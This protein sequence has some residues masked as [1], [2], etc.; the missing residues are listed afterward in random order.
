MFDFKKRLKNKTFC[1]TF[2]IA[3]VSFIYQIL[4]IFE[5]VPKISEEEITNIIVL[6]VNLLAGLGIL[7]NPTTA[8]ITDTEETKET[9]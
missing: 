6:I 1:L 7:I 8:G 2:A 9:E 3:I 4:A 5:I